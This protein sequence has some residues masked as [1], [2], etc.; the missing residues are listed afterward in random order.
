MLARECSPD[1]ARKYVYYYHNYYR[2][3]LL[4]NNTYAVHIESMWE[5]AIATIIY[6]GLPYTVPTCSDVRLQFVCI[7]NRIK[8][9]KNEVLCRLQNKHSIIIYNKQLLHADFV[10]PHV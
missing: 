6:L 7:A 10:S 3:F 8:V 9:H 5:L 2:S 4:S 1:V